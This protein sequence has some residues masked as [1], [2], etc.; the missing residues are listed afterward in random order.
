MATDSSSGTL[1][2][3]SRLT[4][5]SSSSIARSKLSCW[6]STWLFSAI[7]AF[8]WTTRASAQILR[9][10]LLTGLWRGPVAL[11]RARQSTDMGRDRFLQALQI[12]TAL[13]HRNNAPLR[14]FVGKVH[15]PARHPA[16]ILR[17]QVEGGERIAVMRIEAGRDHDQFGGVFLQMRQ[18]AVFEGCVEL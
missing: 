15:Q 9:S 14:G 18:D 4:I 11:L 3:S 10:S 6:S 13:E 7:L 5:D 12:I 16:E 1:P 8:P 2:S 17:L